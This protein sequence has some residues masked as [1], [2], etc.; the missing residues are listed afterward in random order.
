MN[1]KRNLP[2]DGANSGESDKMYKLTEIYGKKKRVLG[3]FKT[4]SEAENFWGSYLYGIM[5]GDEPSKHRIKKTKK[6][7]LFAVRGY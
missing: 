6:G 2:R 7:R 5:G 1:Q 4:H 3:K